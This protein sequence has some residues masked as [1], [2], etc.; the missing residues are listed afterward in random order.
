MYVNNM[1]P[2]VEYVSA[3]VRAKRGKSTKVENYQKN[4]HKYVSKKLWKLYNKNLPK[5]IQKWCKSDKRTQMQTGGRKI[6]NC[7]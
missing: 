3:R 5:V 2:A 6:K 1:N 7:W 4:T